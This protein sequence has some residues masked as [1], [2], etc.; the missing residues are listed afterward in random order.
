MRAAGLRRG[1]SWVVDM[2]L[3]IALLSGS[4]LQAIMECST[5]RAKSHFAEDL[6]SEMN[7]G[8]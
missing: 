1:M 3:T 6:K 5:L 4:G 7:Y 2:P 8:F